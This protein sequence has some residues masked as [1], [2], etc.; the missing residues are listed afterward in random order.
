MAAKKTNKPTRKVIKDLSPTTRA[1][2][3]VKG[4]AD[5]TQDLRELAK[6]LQENMAQ[7]EKIRSAG[8]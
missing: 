6:Q 1:T 8:K 3:K 4:G 7:K 5:N 2:A